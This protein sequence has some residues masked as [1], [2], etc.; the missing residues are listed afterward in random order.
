MRLL[1]DANILLDCLVVEKSGQPRAG[2]SATESLINLCDQQIHNGLIAWHTL[3]ILSYYYRRQHSAEKTASMMNALLAFLEVPTVGHAD[4]V[5]WHSLGASDFED[6]LQIAA[7]VSGKADF[8][9]TRNI[10]D[11]TG[12][13]IPALTPEEFLLK[14]EDPDYA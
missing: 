9:I 7:A 3:P 6:A 1:L 12:A 10:A 5:N 14:R 13:S 2:K 8:V 4:A 11:F